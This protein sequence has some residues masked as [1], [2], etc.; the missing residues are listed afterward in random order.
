MK[1]KTI[2]WSLFDSETAITQELNND[3][4]EVYSI[5]LPSAYIHSK[6]NYITTYAER[7]K[8][9]LELYQHIL[10]YYEGKEQLTMF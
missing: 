6:Y 4:Y 9:P 1:N 3:E 8:V 2:I 10:R 5:G 7:S